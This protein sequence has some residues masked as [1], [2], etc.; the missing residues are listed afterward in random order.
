MKL[1]ELFCKTFKKI[2]LESLIVQYFIGLAIS[3]LLIIILLSTNITYENLQLPEGA[4]KENLWKGSDVLTYVHAARNFISTGTFEF[5]NYISPYQRTIGYPFF[6]T[7]LMRLFSD[8]WLIWAFF[9]Q[10]IIIAFIFPAV[11]K[12]SYIV[13]PDKKPIAV[14]AFIFFIIAWADK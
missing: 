7:I 10:A 5:E 8:N 9:I 6:L 13:F 12:I 1:N 11:S 2:K 4:Y 14:A 3:V